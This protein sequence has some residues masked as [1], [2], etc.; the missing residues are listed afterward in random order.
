MLFVCLFVCVRACICL[1]GCI[2]GVCLCV[3]VCVCVWGGGGVKGI[4]GGGR[5][6][7]G[8]G[9]GLEGRVYGEI[10]WRWATDGQQIL[11]LFHY[12]QSFCRNQTDQCHYSFIFV[13]NHSLEST[14]CRFCDL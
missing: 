10:W 3:C 1:R 12:T 14:L 13:I 4:H 2:H 7:G 11:F 6:W 8:G 9:G 5:G